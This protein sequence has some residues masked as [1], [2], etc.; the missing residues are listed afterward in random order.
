MEK[1]R[2]RVGI[3]HREKNENAFTVILIRSA[4]IEVGIFSCAIP[5]G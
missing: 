4:L 3:V 1:K 5:V 2:E